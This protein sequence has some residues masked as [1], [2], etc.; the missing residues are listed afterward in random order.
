MGSKG[1]I[2]S[3]M[4]KFIIY[5]TVDVYVNGMKFQ[6]PYRFSDIK[7]IPQK[8]TTEQWEYHNPILDLGEITIDLTKEKLKIGLG[9]KWKDTPYIKEVDVLDCGNNDFRLIK[10]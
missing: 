3:T 7:H 6:L 5:P 10:L 8:D 2:F 4:R 1:P 9:I